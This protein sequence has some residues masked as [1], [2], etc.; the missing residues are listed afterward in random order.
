MTIVQSSGG[1]KNRKLA[2]SFGLSLGLRVAW[3]LL[4]YAGVVF[5]ARWFS[6]D[7]YGVIALTL[8]MV[9]FAG[10]LCAMGSQ[11]TL[12]RFLGQY[13]AQDSQALIHGAARFA[14]R[15]VALVSGSVAILAIIAIWTGHAL[16]HVSHPA[17]YSLGFL[18]LPGFALNDTNSAIAR[19]FGSVFL[20][21]A[22]RDVLW[23]GAIILA[24]WLCTRFALGLE[25]F[26][27]LSALLL[28]GFVA[29]QSRASFHRLPPAARA[30]LPAEDRGRWVAVALP[31]WIA[32]VAM[33]SMRTLD[34]VTV[35]LVLDEATVGRYFAA[36]R[37]AILAGFVLNCINL[38]SGPMISHA[39]HSKDMGRLSRI[40][41]LSAV[42]SFAPALMITLIFL[43]FGPFIMS[44]FGP[45]FAEFSGVLVVLACGQTAATF[46][47]SSG[48]LLDLSGHER[49]N[50][51]ILISTALSSLVAMIA[52]GLAFGAIG[53]ASA[54]AA[55]PAVWSFRRWLI[56]RRHTGLDSSALAILPSRQRRLRNP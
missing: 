44:F 8:S 48:L 46:F 16:G 38:V 36:S 20:A 49:Q 42:A 53:V 2:S 51:R 14:Q 47:G 17:A 24:G 30:A 23:R 40:L 11:T 34:V 55:A 6:P 39:F 18:L 33:V 29:W 56:I 45:G 9:T 13:K 43:F 52:L 19:S 50:T 5:L 7:E 15:R 21:L 10:I 22:P 37:S 28:T 26:L 31:I 41:G 25:A 54:A 4:N 35:G 1:K 3:A 27:A 12:L 32:S